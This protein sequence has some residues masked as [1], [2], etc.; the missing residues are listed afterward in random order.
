MGSG[1]GWRSDEEIAAEV[2]RDKETKA[3]FMQAV[4]TWYDR[5][6]RN[7]YK[8]TAIIQANSDKANIDFVNGK[9]LVISKEY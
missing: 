6:A 4:E 3:D 5:A 7:N 9:I 1:H 8:T 2:K